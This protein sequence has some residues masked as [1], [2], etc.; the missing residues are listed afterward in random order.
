MSGIPTPHL[1]RAVRLFTPVVLAGTLTMPLMA[2]AAPKPPKHP[3][4]VATK[5]MPA[6]EEQAPA[7][8]DEP[9]IDAASLDEAPGFSID[10]AHATPGPKNPAKPKAP[11]KPKKAKPEPK[12]KRKP[13]STPSQPTPAPV[14]APT[15]QPSS[16]APVINTVV[17]QRTCVSRRSITLRLDRGYKV[18]AARVL[19][20]GRRLH[21]V[22][23]KNK[24]TVT[25]NLRH[26]ARGTYTVRTIVV[27]KSNKIRTSTRK[28]TTCALPKKKH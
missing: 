10:A 11:K 7:S 2:G 18:R 17:V 22:R 6:A 5:P 26:F 9:T 24:V 14:A 25:I 8:V 4:P 12:P 20:N 1:G 27:T 13:G 3:K 23:R 15:V 28:Y 16:S 19:L 21:V